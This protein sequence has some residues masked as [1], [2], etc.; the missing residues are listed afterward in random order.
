MKLK[1]YPVLTG[2]IQKKLLKYKNYLAIN[3]SICYSV[4]VVRRCFLEYPI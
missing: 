4:A 2:I 1:K 3:N